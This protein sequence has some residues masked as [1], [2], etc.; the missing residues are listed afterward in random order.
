MG[1]LD[2]LFPFLCFL[3]PP[4]SDSQ[5]LFVGNMP[6][7]C[8]AHHLIGL[9]GKYGKVADVQINPKGNRLAVKGLYFPACVPNYGL[10]LS[11]RIALK[12]PSRISPSC[13]T[14]STG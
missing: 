2:S 3:H 12:E 6:L 8:T 5:Q 13:S 1:T 4:P 11:Q 10:C 14:A 7:K 9:F